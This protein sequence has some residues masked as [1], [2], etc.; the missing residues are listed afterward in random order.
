MKLW[1]AVML[2]SLTTLISVGRARSLPTLYDAQK[3]ADYFEPLD[4]TTA[5]NQV[6]GF[7]VERKIAAVSTENG[8]SFTRYVVEDKFWNFQIGDPRD[9]PA[10]YTVALPGTVTRT[11]A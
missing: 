10:A 8:G 2:A 4:T 5:Y 7:G 9:G 11:C 3:G 6:Y 1:G